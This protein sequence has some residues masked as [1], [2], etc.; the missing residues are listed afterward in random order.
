MSG[1]NPAAQLVRRLRVSSKHWKSPLSACHLP[2]GMCAGECATQA[3]CAALHCC[4]AMVTTG[5]SPV[6]SGFPLHSLPGWAPTARVRA[7]RPASALF[8]RSCSRTAKAAH[9]PARAPCS[10]GRRCRCGTGA[11]A[12]P[13][14]TG[15]SPRAPPPSPFGSALRPARQLGTCPHCRREAPESTAAAMK[16]E[17]IIPTALGTPCRTRESLRRLWR[18][19]AWDT[20]TLAGAQTCERRCDQGAMRS[21]SPRSAPSSSNQD[22]NG[23]GGG[24]YI[25]NFNGMKQEYSACS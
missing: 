1:L 19:P 3:P 15:R 11:P 16:R 20:A 12:A 22:A 6:Q 7:G 13:P 25:S 9:A 10:R 4:L 2:C 14:R 5:T 24:F 18:L 17:N 21:C 8:G 23:P